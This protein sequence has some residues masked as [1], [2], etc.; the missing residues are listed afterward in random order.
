M[1]V[2]LR[3]V[4]IVDVALLVD[5]VVAVVVGQ[6]LVEVNVAADPDDLVAG[7]A[8]AVAVVVAFADVV[9]DDD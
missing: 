5:Y 4:G 2:S 9:F 8:A 6:C 3:E 7:T 1:L